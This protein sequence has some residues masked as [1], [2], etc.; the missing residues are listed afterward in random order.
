MIEGSRIARPVTYDLSTVTVLPGLIDTHVHIANHLGP[1]GR[2]TA[3]GETPAQAILF[4][5][6]DAWV[7]LMAG[8]TTVQ[9]I[10]SRGLD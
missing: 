9:S 8:F 10:G 3:P 7:T 2:A 5:A 6:E 4:A 1:D